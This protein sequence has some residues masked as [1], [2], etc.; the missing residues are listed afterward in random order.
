MATDG[1]RRVPLSEETVRAIFALKGKEK[2][3]VVAVRFGVLAVTVSD[4][5]LGKSFR[6][7]TG[8]PEYVAPC[9]RNV[10][11]VGSI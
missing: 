11:A 4:I 8:M 2:Q 1:T 7:I 10:R 6:Q 3:T 9:R 5:W